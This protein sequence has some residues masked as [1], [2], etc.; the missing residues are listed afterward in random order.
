VRPDSVEFA[1]ILLS[2]GGLIGF[3]GLFDITRAM[4]ATLFVASAS[5]GTSVKATAPRPSA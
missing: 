4:A 2:T 5:V 1:A 3:G